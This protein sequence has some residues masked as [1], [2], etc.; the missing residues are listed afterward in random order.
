M[1][2]QERKALG[3]ARLFTPR[4]RAAITLIG[5]GKTQAESARLLALKPTT[6]AS[7]LLGLAGELECQRRVSAVVHAAYKHPDFPLPQRVGPVPG[8]EELDEYASMML[9]AHAEGVTVKRL[10]ETKGI[11]V[12]QLSIFNRQLYD[13][14]G[15]RTPSHAVRLAWRAGWF[16]RACDG[17]VADGAGARR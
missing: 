6:M 4:Q 3:V 11:G 15:A 7:S 14:L 17:A 1:P 13:L 8:I 16:T 2:E 12:A 10:G 9:D 5:L